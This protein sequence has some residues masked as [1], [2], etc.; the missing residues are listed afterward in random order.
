[1]ET[2]CNGLPAA[3]AALKECPLGKAFFDLETLSFPLLV[4]SFRQGDRF[5]P[6]GMSGSQKVKDFFINQKIPR[7][8]RHAYP[9]VLSKGKIIWVGGHRIDNSV[10]VTKATRRV[11]QAELLPE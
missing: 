3:L 11:L 10:R 5:T 8:K 2:G 1:M 7:R 4:R 6:L 9:M